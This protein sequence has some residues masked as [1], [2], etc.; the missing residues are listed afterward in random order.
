MN[1]VGFVITHVSG[2]LNDQRH[3]KQFARWSR[4][5]LLEYLNE[6]LTEIGAYRPEAYATTLEHTLVQ[7]S[8]QSLPDNGV[9]T[10]ISANADGSTAHICD[11]KMLKGFGAYSNCMFK[12]V[13]VNGNP[14]YN[15]K[16][17]AVDTDNN[18][19]FYVSPP[20]PGGMAP[21]I[22]VTTNSTP[23]QYTMAN[24]NIPLFVA[25]KYYNNLIDFMTARAYQLDTESQIAQRQAQS[26][27]QLF[28]QA[29]GAK[30]KIDS[31]RGSGYYLGEVGSGDSRSVVR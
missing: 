26:L 24:W 18:R 13:F 12:P 28:Y 22:M 4:S 27:F 31:A 10:G 7:G 16:S 21:K 15:V 19:I 14:I 9:L 17:Y 23:P 3:N 2:Q 25:D 29:M 5:K 1:T 20:V 6:A 30:Y 8:R 11:D